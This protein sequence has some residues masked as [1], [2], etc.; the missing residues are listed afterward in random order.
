Q[1][2]DGYQWRKYGQKVTKDN[3]SPR[4]YKTILAATYEGGHNHSLHPNITL[5]DLTQTGL[6]N[7]E[8]QC[9]SKTD[10]YGMQRFLVEQMASSLAQVP[11]FKASLAS[12][13]S[14]GS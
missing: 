11:I 4:A 2:K 14:E 7:D 12:A 6:C 8:K 9:N 5:L 10:H 13:I 3:P 1:V